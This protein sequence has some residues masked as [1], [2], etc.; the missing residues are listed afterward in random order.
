MNQRG[1]IKILPWLLLATAFAGSQDRKTTRSKRNKIPFRE[2]HD[3]VAPE[4]S[5]E[6][7]GK[8]WELWGNIGNYGDILG[9]LGKY[10]FRYFKTSTWNEYVFVCMSHSTYVIL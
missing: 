6:Y 4:G 3:G 7:M 8:Y 10:R 1:G 9:F 2:Y 5:R